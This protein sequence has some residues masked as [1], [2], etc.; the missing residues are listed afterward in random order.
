MRRN[1]PGGGQ[2]GC[3]HRL[4]FRSLNR[5]SVP[6][7]FLISRQRSSF[8]VG[9]LFVFVFFSP[10]QRV[11]NAVLQAVGRRWYIPWMVSLGKTH[12]SVQ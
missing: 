8:V 7:S 12:M 2:V 11:I 1:G 9:F 5:E 3:R 4:K 10:D 6:Y